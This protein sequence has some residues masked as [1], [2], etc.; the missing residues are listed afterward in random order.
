MWQDRIQGASQ[1]FPNWACGALAGYNT[2]T[3]C[4]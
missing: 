2:V 4:C 3:C 1:N